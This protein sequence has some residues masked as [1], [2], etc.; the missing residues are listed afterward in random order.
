MDSP[1]ATLEVIEVAADGAR[2]PMRLELGQPRPD[3]RGTWV[4]QLSVDRHHLRLE[5]I[6]GED[7]LQALCLALRLFRLH[8]ELA[9][10]RGS[11]LVYPDDGGEFPLHAYFERVLNENP[12]A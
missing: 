2:I 4:C 3:G 10:E 8:L 6:C 1:V 9:F 11:R 5:D 12:S 7:S